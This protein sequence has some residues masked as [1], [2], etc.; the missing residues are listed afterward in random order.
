MNNQS[1][2]R[3]KTARQIRKDAADT[4]FMRNHPSEHPSNGEGADTHQ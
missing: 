3:R 4:A 2:I 1:Y